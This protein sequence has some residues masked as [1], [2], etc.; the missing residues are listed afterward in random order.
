MRQFTIKHALERKKFKIWNKKANT[1]G[2]K[3]PYQSCLSW[4]GN[5]G[6]TISNAF[7]KN[8]S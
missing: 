1:L 7:V 2:K 6:A 8:I 3:L 4:K 5:E